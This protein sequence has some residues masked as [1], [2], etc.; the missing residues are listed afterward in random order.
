MT[1]KQQFD[2]YVANGLRKQEDDI[3]IVKTLVNKLIA[4]CY[5]PAK[6]DWM[7]VSDRERIKGFGIDG[8]EP[9]NWGS[10]SCFEAKKFDDGSYQAI[11][12]EAQEGN[13]PTFCEYIRSYMEAWGWK[14]IVLTEW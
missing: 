4:S 8:S 3:E 12:D 9:I 10:L 1:H 13:C 14:I 6:E 7:F 5:K 2:L 11:I